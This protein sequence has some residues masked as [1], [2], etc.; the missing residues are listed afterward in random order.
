MSSIPQLY[1]FF[2]FSSFILSINRVVHFILLDKFTTKT[3]IYKLSDSNLFI[4]RG[5]YI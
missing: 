3:T 1:T 5:N 4:Y 2:Y